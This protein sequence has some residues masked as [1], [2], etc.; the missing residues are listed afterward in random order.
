M[1]VRQLRAAFAYFSPIKERSGLSFIRSRFSSLSEA[2]REV[3]VDYLD[4]DREGI[5]V[6]AMNRPSRKNALGRVFVSQLMTKNVGFKCV[7]YTWS[8][9]IAQEGKAVARCVSYWI[10][11]KVY[12]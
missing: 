11:S 6:V 10:L 1:A 12:M 8:G 7:L 3:R 9:A 4:G 2:S 5:A